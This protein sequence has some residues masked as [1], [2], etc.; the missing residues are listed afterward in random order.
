VW[1]ADYLPFGKASVTIG[2]VGNDLRFAGQYYDSETGLH[3]NYHRYYDPKL[4]RYLRADPIGLLGG[5]NLYQYASANPINASD[6]FGLRALTA[7]EIS[8]LRP[9]YGD[10]VDY[11]AIDIK[12][13]GIPTWGGYAAV[14]KNNIYFPSKEYS[15][16]FSLGEIDDRAW[17]VHEVAH[18]WQYQNIPDYHWRKALAEQSLDDTYGYCLDSSKTLRNYRWEQQATIIEDYYVLTQGFT[19]SRIQKSQ[20]EYHTVVMGSLHPD[21]FLP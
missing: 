2:T 18:V 12:K 17:L 21:R 20:R 7:G 9:I 10:K 11:S 6:P 14:M 16:D 3:Y 1:S 4:G 19:R 15:E 8:F 5:I 13:G